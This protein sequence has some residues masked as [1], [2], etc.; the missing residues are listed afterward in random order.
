MK[1]P[2]QENIEIKIRHWG[3]EAA[4]MSNAGEAGVFVS[5]IKIK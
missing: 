3:G 5:T 2:C 4:P 1:T